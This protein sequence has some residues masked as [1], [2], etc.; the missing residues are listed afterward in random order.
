MSATVAV[1]LALALTN[2]A[3]IAP[4]SPS[5]STPATPATTATIAT[6]AT[7]ATQTTTPTTPSAAKTLRGALGEASSVV[8]IHG[9]PGHFL[10]ADDERGILLVELERDDDQVSVLMGSPGPDS[11]RDLEGLTAV[12]PDLLIRSSPAAF[13]AIAERSGRVLAFQRAGGV[14]MTAA[15]LAHPPPSKGKAKPNKGWEGIAFLSA[16]LAPDHAPHVVAVHEGAPKAVAFF[17]WPALT[18]ERTIALDDRGVDGRGLDEALAD[19]SDVCVDP[20]DGS[21][22]LLSDESARIVRVRIVL[23]DAGLARATL[24]EVGRIELPMVKGEKPEG[25]TLDDDGALWIVTDATGR[26]LRVPLGP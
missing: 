2:A 3:D 9:E 1:A 11:F 17:A 20:K 26:L 18:P 21:L 24:R 12:P 7:P 10:V 14:S 23:G 4:V 16:A 25:L 22:L 15:T 13:I 19:L 6:T 5:T 8:A